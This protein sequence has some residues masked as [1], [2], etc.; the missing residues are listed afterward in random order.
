M[1]NEQWRL[2]KKTQKC[3]DHRLYND[4]HL[5]DRCFTSYKTRFKLKSPR[6]STANY[7][8]L[9]TGRECVK[10]NLNKALILLLILY[11]ASTHQITFDH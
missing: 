8:V 10:G 4:K 3:H 9:V 1:E 11:T 5:I 7:S 6:L 2:I